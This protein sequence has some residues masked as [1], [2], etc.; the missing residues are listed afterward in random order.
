MTDAEYHADAIPGGSLSQ[1]GARKL[2]PPSCPARF[3][4]DRQHPPIPT[5][6]FSLGHAAHRQV[7]GAGAE[8]AIID[9]ADW[10]TK[11]AKEERAAAHAAGLI[12]V[13]THQARQVVDMVAALRAHPLAAELLDL[14]RITV[15][16]SIFWT[17]PDTGVWRRAR[18]DAVNL[19]D[20]PAIADYKTTDA[21]D[22][23]H[24]SRALW[25]YGY[26]MQGGWYLDG[27]AAV[28]LV[29]DD[30][31]FFLVA[32]EKEP[33]YLVSV[34]EPDAAALRIG[35]QRNRAAIEIY[36]DCTAA[37]VWPGHTA[38][39]DIPLVSLPAWVER[40]HTTTDPYEE[41]Y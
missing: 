17:D 11:A 8:L 32:Q 18:L 1:S 13:L 38:T 19:A 10:R 9:A 24:L 29:P 30:T 28:N 41:M 22:L 40:Q 20:T 21:G 14:D 39:D 34:V 33:P 36:R 23:D 37:D 3:A 2:L 15:E 5:A 31:R 4:Y 25:N 16:Q 26:A 27:G 7:L 6:E 35:R 12:P